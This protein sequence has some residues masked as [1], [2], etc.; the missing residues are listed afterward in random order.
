M[1]REE[2]KAIVR[3]LGEA[4]HSGS[5]DAFDEILAPDYVRNDPT[6]LLKN[7]DREK[8][9]QS[10]ALFHGA[11]PDF[12]LTEEELLTD[13]DKVMGRWAF[14]GTHTGP[15]GKLPPSGKQVTFPIFTIY[16]IENGRIAE[17][18]HLFDALG[19]WEQL[20]PEV[21][22]LLAKAQG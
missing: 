14:Q 10:V 13:G 11:F 18:W 20:V 5:L 3:R 9:K 8:I 22:E 2:N 6:S 15:F 21:G 16:R 7:A 12:Q 4:I 19:F 17:D 1:S